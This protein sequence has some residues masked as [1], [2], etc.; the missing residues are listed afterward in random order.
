MVEKTHTAGETTGGRYSNLL[1]PFHDIGHRIADFF[2]PNAD[3]TAT[4]EHYEINMELPGVSLEDIHID[5]HEDT[6][7]IRGEKKTEREEKGKTYFFSERTFGSF[8]RS[9]RLP[10]NAE[11]EKIAADFK[12]GVLSIQIP[13]SGPPPEK[14]RRI[15]I[16]SG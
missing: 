12:D 10:A 11:A 14:S 15:E 3:A 13:R 4:S 7:T 1:R 2:A 9:F 6:L 16:K 8:E 5:L